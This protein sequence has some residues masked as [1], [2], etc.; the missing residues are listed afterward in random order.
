MERRAAQVRRAVAARGVSRDGVRGL[1]G[2]DWYETVFEVID[3]RSF[4]NLWFWMAVAVIWS[5][6]SHYVLGVPYDL[7]LRARRHG[8]EA[9]ADLEALVA[10][11]VRRMAHI[12]QTAGLWLV[13]FG[14]FVLTALAILGFVYRIEYAQAVFLIAA[15]MT[16]VFWLTLRTASGIHHHQ[17][18]GPDLWRVLTRQRFMVQGIGVVAI[19]V[20]TM[21]GMWQNLN[22]SA[23]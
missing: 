10:I 23:L 13:G 5:T 21:W 4:S 22:A 18:T 7:V 19:F 11:H 16:L 14:A 3:M 6:A 9:A 17:P 15:P 20:T 1:V 2:V 8:G 12:V